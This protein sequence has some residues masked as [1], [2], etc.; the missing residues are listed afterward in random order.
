MTAP[1]TLPDNTLDR[2]PPTRH[3]RLLTAL[4]VSQTGGYIAV[5]T[6][7]QLLLTLHLADLAGSEADR[8]FGIATGLG[9]FVSLLINPIAG[10]ISD[11][12]TA[13]FG[14]RRTWILAGALTTA[15]ALLALGATTTVWQVVLAWCVISALAGFWFAATTAAV[16]DQVDPAR[17]GGV[18]GLLGLSVA[19]GPLL[20][21]ALVN[22]LPA[23]STGQWLILAVVAVFT[24]VVAV[25]L[26]RERPAQS[27]ATPG[28][29]WVNPRTHP[30]FAW[31]WLVRML[32]SCA[33]ASSSYYAFY[34][35]EQFD[36]SAE[37]LGPLVLSI[38]MTSV[39]ALA[40]TSVVAGYAS[41]AIGRQKPFVAAAGI[42]GAL[43]LIT[44]AFA[45]SIPVVYFASVLVGV[46]L[47]LFVSIDLAMCLR[48][49]PNP[50]D[51]GKDLAVLNMASAL[52]P[53][54]VPFLAAGLLGLGGYPLFF[55]VL[56]VFGIA[57]AIAVRRIPEMTRA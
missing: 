22:G 47:G 6:P 2:S 57:G 18:S 15:A 52:P 12:T 56:A 21:I 19:L 25:L 35:I 17:R 23:G 40:F 48:V 37:R 26:I 51:S 16:A 5:Q 32:I 54:I 31:A 39:A 50:D 10:R 14:R 9:A 49:L 28:P 38:A 36:V 55:G 29:Y 41:D 8:A 53:A 11:R 27:T 33:Y 46:G 1:T 20:G 34:L 30:D 3:R 42:L 7:V 43:A 4:L 44:L 24:G 13:R 45:P